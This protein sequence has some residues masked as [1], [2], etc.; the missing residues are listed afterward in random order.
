MGVFGAKRGFQGR[1]WKNRKCIDLV[2]RKEPLCRRQAL[3]LCEYAGLQKC[4][5]EKLLTYIREYEQHY[6]ASLSELINTT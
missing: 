5:K 2:G 3:L 1:I 4:R 6:P